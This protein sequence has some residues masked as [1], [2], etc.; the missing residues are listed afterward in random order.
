MTS[1]AIGLALL[2]ALLSGCSG[3]GFPPPAQTAPQAFS[4]DSATIGAPHVTHQDVYWT[5]F[6]GAPYPQVQIAAAPLKTAS[7]STSIYSSRKNNLLDSSGMAVDSSGRLWILSYGKN[8]GAPTSALVFELPL[9]AT[10]IPKYTFVLSGTSGSDALAFGPSGNLW[11]TAPG[12]HEVLEYKGPFA[13]SG[14]LKPVTTITAVSNNLFGIAVDKSANVYF[15]LNNSRGSRSIAVEKPPYKASPYYLEGLMYPGGLIFDKHG[16]LYA[17]TNGT[18]P[19]VVR[20]NSNHLQSGDKP[21]IVDPTGVPAGS[22]EAAFAL[23]AKGDLYAAN[24]GNAKTAGID[25]WPL[26]SK[27]FSARLAPSVLY[28]NSNLR[29]VGCAWGIA[30]K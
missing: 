15:S 28:T 23:T 25:V 4:S 16:N 13:K 21:N 5:L 26:G 18:P 30:I 12:Y 17:S 8:S 3:G 1:R 20:Y 7:K 2:I 10:S 14:T 11:V 9:T 22:Y 24:C 19:A 6:A 29:L 27:T